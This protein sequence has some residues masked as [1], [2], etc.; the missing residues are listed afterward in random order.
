MTAYN[1]D[2]DLP[3]RE[4]NEMQQGRLESRVRDMGYG[5][6]RQT[7]FWKIPGVDKADPED[8][9][10][11]PNIDK[12]TIIRLGYMFNQNSVIH[13][14]GGGLL[15]ISTSKKGT[16][17]YRAGEVIRT[18]GRIAIAQKDFLDAFSRWREHRLK[19]YS[20][21]VDRMK[22]VKLG[23]PEDKLIDYEGE[24]IPVE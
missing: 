20:E 5:F 3:G 12:N 15:L 8:S 2:G 10:I 4:V 18:F 9:I 19:F 11:I 14:N 24:G 23:L 1:P 6:I 22:L 16:D 21:G 7:A 17:G 13:K